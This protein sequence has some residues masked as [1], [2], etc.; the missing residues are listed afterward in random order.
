VYRNSET[1]KNFWEVRDFVRR[2]IC[3]SV[4]RHWTLVSQFFSRAVVLWHA[5]KL[6]KTEVKNTLSEGH[7]VGSKK[8]GIVHGG[9]GAC[10]RNGMGR[11]ASMPT[12]TVLGC[13]LCRRISR[14]VVTYLHLPSCHCISHVPSPSP[15][16][17]HD[18]GRRGMGVVSRQR[19]RHCGHWGSW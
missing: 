11:C 10:P 2:F 1:P 15:P 17:G 7:S 9:D 18:P 16:D 14:P 3:R 13:G 19:S 6:N 8:K 12:K 5:K 4:R